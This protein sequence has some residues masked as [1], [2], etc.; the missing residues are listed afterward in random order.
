M[1]L[2]LELCKLAVVLAFAA[3]AIML[4]GSCAPQSVGSQTAAE[5]PVE[6]VAA[7][8]RSGGIPVLEQRG[9]GPPVYRECWSKW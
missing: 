6:T 2:L 9:A 5:R 3:W 1:K 7:C 8:R 4:V